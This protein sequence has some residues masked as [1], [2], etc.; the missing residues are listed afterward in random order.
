MFGTRILLLACL[1][2]LLIGCGA[3]TPT[4]SEY[5]GEV[6]ELVAAMETRFLL[7]DDGW[8]SKPPSRDG[9]LDYWDERLVIRK[10]FL[11]GIKALEAPNEVQEMHEAS[12]ELF[13]RI[14]NA[15]EAIAVRVAALDAVTEH[16]QW[17]AM[18]EGQASLAILEEVYEFCRVSQAEFDAT[19]DELSFGVSAWLEP[20]ERAAVRVA[21]GC[22]PA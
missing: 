18:P 1:F 11:A 21:F 19:E 14:T 15:D 20:E 22:P 13:E 7:L 5:A 2:W 17:L 4:V 8:E 3:G 6:E 12:I 9:A 16:R 10:D